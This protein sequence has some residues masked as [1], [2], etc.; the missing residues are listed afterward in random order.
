MLA[1]EEHRKLSALDDLAGDALQLRHDFFH[2]REGELDFRQRADADAVDVGLRL[3]VPELH[4]RRGDEYLVRAGA[5]ARHVRGRAVE[6]NRQDHD[7]GLIEVDHGRRGAAELADGHV[8]VLEGKFRH[9]NDVAGAN[10][11][12]ARR[13]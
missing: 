4:M 6:R 1:A 2:R 5:R 13:P 10:Y 7:A 12:G 9:R 11:I 3:L 8:L